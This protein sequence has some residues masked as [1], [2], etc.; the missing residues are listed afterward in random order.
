MLNFYL[1]NFQAPYLLLAIIFCSRLSYKTQTLPLIL[2]YPWILI[3]MTLTSKI[4]ASLATCWLV[5]VSTVV[6]IPSLLLFHYVLYSSS[7]PSLSSM[8]ELDLYSGNGLRILDELRSTINLFVSLDQLLSIFIWNLY[9]LQIF[10]V[11]ILSEVFG[12]LISEHHI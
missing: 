11:W 1:T 5:F 6:S 2:V 3:S 7:L 8:H 4:V 10:K 12:S 9:F